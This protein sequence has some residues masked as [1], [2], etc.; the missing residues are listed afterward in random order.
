MVGAYVLDALRTPIGRYGGVLASTRPDDL[1]A[2]VM[3]A[4]VERGEL[5]AGDIDDVFMGC[6]NQAG[7]GGPEAGVSLR[8]LGDGGL[9][10]TLLWVMRRRGARFGLATMCIGVG[11]GLA[12][13]VEAP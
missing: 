10:T 12:T 1:A 6:A 11:Q 13:V 4:A 9:L 7:D 5:P 8:R 2:H 3:R